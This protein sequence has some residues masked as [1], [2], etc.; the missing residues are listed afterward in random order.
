LTSIAQILKREDLK[1]S[2]AVPVNR[3]CRFQTTTDVRRDL[4]CR[5]G[6]SPAEAD[7]TEAVA[8]QLLQRKFDSVLFFA[9]D[10]LVALNDSCACVPTQYRIVLTGRV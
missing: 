5:A 3:T 10:K 2:P 1:V 7:A 8:L 4:Y 9:R 6:A